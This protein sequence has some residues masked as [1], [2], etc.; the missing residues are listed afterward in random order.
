M[1]TSVCDGSFKVKTSEPQPITI[2]V[3][4][5]LWGKQQMWLVSLQLEAPPELQTM[6]CRLQAWRRWQMR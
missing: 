2:K 1:H 4:S 3:L 6:L 5:H